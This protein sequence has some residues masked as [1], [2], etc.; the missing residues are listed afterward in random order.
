MARSTSAA[1]VAFHLRRWDHAVGHWLFSLGFLPDRD[2]STLGRIYAYYTFLLGAFWLLAS[3]GGVLTL[4][5]QASRSAPQ[6]QAAMLTALPTLFGLSVVGLA[7]L[8]LARSPITFSAEDASYLASAPVPRRSIA[9]VRFVPS[10]LGALGFIV[11]LAGVAAVLVSG[12]PAHYLAAMAASVPLALGA[13]ALAWA[14][15]LVR[16]GFV[17]RARRTALWALPVLLLAAI[18][19]RLP[20]AL[21]PGRWLTAVATG[22]PVSMG[23]LLAFAAGGAALL[24]AFASAYDLTLVTDESL[25]RSFLRSI[26]AGRRYSPAGAAQQKK[27]AALSRRR[28][29]FRLPSS[30]GTALLVARAA[31]ARL[32][33]PA[34]LWGTLRTAAVLL[35]GLDLAVLPTKGTAWLMW[36]LIVM[37]FP[38]TALAEDYAADA[39]PFLRQFLPMNAL[40]LAAVDALLPAAIVAAAGLVELLFLPLPA[41]GV[42]PALLLLVALIAVSTISQALREAGP[43]VL[44]SRLPA[45]DLLSAAVG[46][47]LFI[48]L[49]VAEHAVMA[50]AIVL[51]IAAAAMTGLLRP[52]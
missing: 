19:L 17:S 3:W 49:G 7:A 31:I 16:M 15:G 21:A 25:R 37:L 41:A 9:L 44:A 30:S 12:T 5:L 28:A 2:A 51:L 32:R 45:P 39:R 46:Y 20:Y 10:W 26:A 36:V 24:I 47:G 50:A 14:I 6:L 43:E 23:G 1:V 42:L 40:Q 22:G 8:A 4:T 34:S 13:Q 27:A 18:A 38:P 29:R 35:G 11:L 33:Y 48:W 52:D